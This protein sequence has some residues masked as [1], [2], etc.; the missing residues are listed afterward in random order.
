L[1]YNRDRWLRRRVAGLDREGGVG[2]IGDDD[3]NALVAEEILD[4]V[5]PGTLLC[6]LGFPSVE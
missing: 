2:K 1:R 6:L 5:L 3:A 4:G